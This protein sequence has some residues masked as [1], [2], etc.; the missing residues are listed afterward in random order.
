MK[1][2][3]FGWIFLLLFRFFFFN[4]ATPFVLLD[5]LLWLFIGWRYL[6]TRA[7]IIL[8]SVSISALV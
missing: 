4:L 8:Q 7:Y 3:V 1:S 5:F 6:G 2:K